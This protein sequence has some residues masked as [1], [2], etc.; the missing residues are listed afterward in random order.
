MQARIHKP[1]MRLA[2]PRLVCVIHVV[3][4]C[5][6]IHFHLL[7]FVMDEKL[8]T[9]LQRFLVASTCL[10]C[11]KLIESF[12]TFE[13]ISKSFSLAFQRWKCIY[14]DVSAL[15]NQNSLIIWL[16]IKTLRRRAAI[17]EAILARTLPSSSTVTGHKV[18]LKITFKETPSNSMFIFL[19]IILK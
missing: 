9:T 7:E 19:K 4:P 3:W 14:F 10:K 18:K 15:G 2:F 17:K 8:K 16:Q 11:N 5:W 12:W 6:L 1:L 13:N